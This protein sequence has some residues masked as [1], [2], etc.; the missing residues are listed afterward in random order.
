MV[1]LNDSVI[2]LKDPLCIVEMTGSFITKPVQILSGSLY[3]KRVQSL[4]VDKQHIEAIVSGYFEFKAI[5]NDKPVTISEG[6]FDLGIG[7]DNFYF[8]E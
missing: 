7:S 6:R 4:S 8:N 2:D 3:F 5:I 1:A